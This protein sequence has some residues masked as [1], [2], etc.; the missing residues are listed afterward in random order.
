MSILQ[1]R[2][3]I[4][5]LLFFVPRL[6][7]FGNKSARKG[8]KRKGKMN[9]AEKREYHIY[10]AYLETRKAFQDETKEQ[11]IWKM[12]S[13]ICHWSNGHWSIRK[14]ATQLQEIIA[15]LIFNELENNRSDGWQ[16]FAVS[17][18]LENWDWWVV[19]QGCEFERVG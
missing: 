3:Y 18:F 14:P 1:Q 7:I 6:I 16:T 4:K 9:S 5:L 12:N 19:N 13:T 10:G 2:D 17:D 8:T 11:V 15:D